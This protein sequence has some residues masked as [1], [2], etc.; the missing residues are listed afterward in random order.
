MFCHIVKLHKILHVFS[1]LSDKL[2]LEKLNL[3]FQLE[4]ASTLHD[5]SHL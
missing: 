2:D 3:I 4:S 5:V 1:P